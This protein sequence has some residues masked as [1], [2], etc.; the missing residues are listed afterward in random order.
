MKSGT[1]GRKRNRSRAVRLLFGVGLV[2]SAA[3]IFSIMAISCNFR[4]HSFNNRNTV[5][6]L[7]KGAVELIF[8]PSKFQW[9]DST[10]LYKKHR[11]W[12]SDKRYPLL[13]PISK[14]LGKGWRHTMIPLWIPGAMCVGGAI[15]LMRKQ[16]DPQTC[17]KC[18]YSLAGL[19]EDGRQC[20]EC[21]SVRR[22]VPRSYRLPAARRTGA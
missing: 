13:V 8:Q 1:A 15:V 7:R 21:G 12:H 3:L 2:V 10:P 22:G 17:R 5:F 14:A 11:S 18:G 9:D 16:R 19:P 4:F 6:A 20:P